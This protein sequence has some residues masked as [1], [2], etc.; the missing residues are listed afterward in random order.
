[1]LF[2]AKTASCGE[3]AARCASNTGFIVEQV[4]V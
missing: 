4:P 2:A 3:V 1:M